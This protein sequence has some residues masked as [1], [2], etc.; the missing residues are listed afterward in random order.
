MSTAL[1]R[2]TIASLL[3]TAACAGVSGRSTAPDP[4]VGLK[5][6]LTDAA[7]AKANLN[8][9]SHVASPPVFDKQTN[10]DL[11]FTG[12]YAI[13]GN[14]NGPVIWDVSNPSSPKLVSSITCPASQNDVSVYA[15]LLFVSVESNNSTVDCRTATL[16]TVSRER[17]RGVRIFDISDIRNPKLVHNVQTCRGSH[18]HSVLEDPRD[19]NNIYIYVSGSSNVRSPTELAGCVTARPDSAQGSALWRIEIIRVPLANPASATVVNRADIFSGL[20]APPTHGEAEAE[21]AEQ[22]R[23]LDSARR[24]GGYI[25]RDRDGTEIAVGPGFLRI[26]LDS[27]VKLRGGTGAAEATAADSAVLRAALQSFV[28]G[29]Y[30]AQGPMP[31]PGVS[32][33]S[34]FRQCHDITLYPAL[35]LAGGACEGHGILLDIR[36]PINPRRIHQVADSNFA[37]WHSATFNNDGTKVLFSDEWGGGGAPKC[38]A[39]D[40]KEWGANAIF[41]IVNGRME[42]RSYYKLPAVQTSLENCVAHNGSLVPIPGRDVMVQGWYQGGI[43]VFDWTDARNPVEIAYHDRGPVDSTRFT[44]GGSW[45]AYWYNGAI[46]SS[47]IARGL[48]AFELTPSEHLTQNEIDA[49]KTVKLS[50]FNAQGQ[51]KFSWPPSFPLARAYLD[52]LERKNCLPAGRISAVRGSLTTAESQTGSQRQ[53]TLSQVVSQLEGDKRASCDVPKLNK[54]QQTITELSRPIVP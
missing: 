20:T 26:R 30:A 47:E 31:T 21:L 54:L 19:R 45:S 44:M 43:S 22:R 9:M 2:F 29:F 34:S 3:V 15:N 14:Y 11:A 16:D 46:V 18:T 8:V 50:Y 38:R 27:I 41:E 40:K 7:E 39:T 12:N 36:D 49:A 32:P 48:D 4:R 53:A 23:R 24:V 10:S 5:G 1:S 35:G 13:Q 25:A 28:D 6:G 37:Y 42:F 51:P 17:M 52:Q 33:I